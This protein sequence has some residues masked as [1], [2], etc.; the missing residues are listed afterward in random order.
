L[1]GESLRRP[2]WSEGSRFLAPL[3]MTIKSN[4]ASLPE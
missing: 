2:E 1:T 3:E 4:R